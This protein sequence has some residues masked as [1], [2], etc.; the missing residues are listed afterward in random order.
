LED[1]GSMFNYFTI[2]TVCLTEVQKINV[3]ISIMS[4]KKVR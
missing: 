1:V 4:T 2:I 3:I